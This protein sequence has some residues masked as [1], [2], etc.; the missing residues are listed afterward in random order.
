MEWNC[1]SSVLHFS[2]SYVAIF[3]PRTF[4]ASTR[5]TLS[6]TCP[7]RFFLLLAVCASPSKAPVLLS[8]ASD[9]VWMRPSMPGKWRT[10]ILLYMCVFSSLLQSC[11]HQQIIFILPLTLQIYAT[12][13]SRFPD[14]RSTGHGDDLLEEGWGFTPKCMM[15]DAERFNGCLALTA[16]CTACGEVRTS[17]LLWCVYAEKFDADAKTI[18]PFSV[19]HLILFIF[20]QLQ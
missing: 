11:S 3:S 5:W 12:F 9:S 13:L 18:A 1:T 16:L 19:A 8:S 20:P 17:Y 7:L 15:D 4:Q 10:V 2:I 6:G 14:C